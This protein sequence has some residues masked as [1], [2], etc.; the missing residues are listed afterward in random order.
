MTLSWVATR[1][2]LTRGMREGYGGACHVK[3]V[4]TSG[5]KLVGKITHECTPSSWV[6]GEIIVL[7][8]TR[9]SR[10]LHHVALDQV[11][12]LTVVLT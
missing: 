9:N 2:Q 1:D 6:M 10:E 4:L 12:V 7:T 5:D 11:A 8:E 3:L